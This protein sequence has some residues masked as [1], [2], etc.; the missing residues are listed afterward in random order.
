[1]PVGNRTQAFEQCHFQWSWVIPKLYFKV[2]TRDTVAQPLCDS[3]TFLYSLLNTHS[4]KKPQAVQ[5]NASML[6]F[7]SLRSCTS[8]PAGLVSPYMSHSVPSFS[9]EPTK[10]AHRQNGPNEGRKRPTQTKTAPMEE[11]TRPKRPQLT[12]KTAHY[13]TL[14]KYGINDVN[15]CTW[16]MPYKRVDAAAVVAAHIS[17][18]RAW[19]TYSAIRCWVLR[20]CF[21]EMKGRR[22]PRSFNLSAGVFESIQRSMYIRMRLVCAALRLPVGFLFMLMM[23]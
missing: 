11:K 13:V 9:R 17:V 2:S 14:Y 23:M 22:P 3:S 21:H 5:C 18:R 20:R 8:F 12:S 15:K 7:H 10:T 19:E 16:G 1:M 6:S 4:L